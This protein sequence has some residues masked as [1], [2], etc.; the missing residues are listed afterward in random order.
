MSES[1]M[2][3]MVVMVAALALALV[4]C[5]PG[6]DEWTQEV[7]DNFLDGCLEASGGEEAY[8]VCVLERL[9]DTY[10]LAEFEAIERELEEADVMPAELEGMIED[11]LEEHLT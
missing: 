7:R 9:E 4:A 5:G 6:G 10:T 3:R 2:H 11:C 1:V 8:C